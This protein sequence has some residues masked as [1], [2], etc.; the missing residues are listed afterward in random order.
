[1]MSPLDL[2]PNGPLYWEPHPLIGCSTET[3]VQILFSVLIVQFQFVSTS[4]P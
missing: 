2:P 3:L 4:L 1:M